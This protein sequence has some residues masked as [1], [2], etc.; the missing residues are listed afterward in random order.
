[1][2]WTLL[3]A[4]LSWGGLVVEPP[5]GWTDVTGSR[6][7]R[8]VVASLKGP[9]TSSFVLTRIPPVAVEN[10]AV[11]RGLLLEVL[12]EMESRMKLGFKPASN[13]VTTTFSNNMTAHYLRAEGREK[14]KLILAVTQAQGDTLLL[15]L[16]SAVPDTILPSLMNGIKQGGAGASTVSADGQLSFG[17][18]GLKARALS[19]RE[20]K[21]NLVA[22]LSH[23]DTEV[24][25][26]RL[27]EDGTPIK[28]QPEL[29]QQTVA[30]GGVKPETLGPNRRMETPAGPEGIYALAELKE[31]GWLGS[32]Y[33][34]WAYWGYSVVAKGPKAEESL[35]ALLATLE[36]GPQADA[37]LL[38]STPRVPRET[39]NFSVIFYGL[40]ILAVLALAWSRMR[41]RLT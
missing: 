37:K 4:A 30:A 21:M 25:V 1:M 31:G 39:R 36:P 9:E 24:V 38:A 5:P 7:G 16:V 15:T 10:R 26:V 12:T 8:N 40:G 29:V 22:A 6:R 17:G 28:D 14:T 18:S 41:N 33:L 3:L 20:R 11:V 19:T 32:G 13:L 27:P 35:E 2:H 23:G 34:P